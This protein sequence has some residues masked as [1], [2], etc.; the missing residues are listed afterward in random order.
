MQNLYK[1]LICGKNTRGAVYVCPM[2]GNDS[3]YD[4]DLGYGVRDK[5][6]HVRGEEVY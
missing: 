5:Y 6:E 1:C 2:C 3:L 4:F